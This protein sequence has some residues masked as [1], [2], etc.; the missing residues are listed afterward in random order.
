MFKTTFY[1]NRQLLTLTIIII[2]V[3]GLSAFLGLP[4]L[5]DPRISNRNPLVITLLPGA[6]AERV[7]TLITEKIE[8]ELR[9][10]S[11]IKHLESQSRSNVS[12]VQIELADDVYDTEKI[13]TKIRD[14]LAD[15]E[16]ELP[17]NAT[18]PEF[19][20]ERGALAYTLIL[21]VTWNGDQSE[22]RL[23]MLN[24]TAE[25]IADR[26]RNITGTD[27]V[28][29]YGGPNEEIK[30]ELSRDK[31]AELGLTA[32]NV[33]DRI[34]NS[35]SKIASGTL[36]SSSSNVVMEVQG[37]FATTDRIASIPIVSGQKG[38]VVRLSDI[39]TIMKAWQDPPDEI[40]IADSQRAIYVAVRMLDDQ[41]VD[42]W[43]MRT[44]YWANSMRHFL[45]LSTSVRCFSSNNIHSNVWASWARTC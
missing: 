35:D 24:R 40:A 38:E 19:D 5:E 25:E 29:I 21:G 2:V 9:D 31:L 17:T 27:L 8:T 12:F 10:I 34:S 39:A 16:S 42:G 6:T 11:E 4:R 36:R 26:M 28:R 1:Q 33:T 43:S 44:G 22:Q 3:A 41:R 23:T 14:K 37:A 13:Y 45:H 20:G 7:E 32:Q 30:I 18:K 15:I